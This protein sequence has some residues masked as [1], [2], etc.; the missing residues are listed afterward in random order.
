MA[1][2]WDI[3]RVVF[4]CFALYRLAGLISTEEGPYL[5]FLY[6]DDDQTG[7]FKWLREKAG[8]RPDRKAY[9]NTGRYVYITNLARGLS[10]PLCTA[11]YLAV[12][13]ILLMQFP[14]IPGNLILAW[15]GIWGV[16]TFLENLTSDEAVQS[17]IEEVA[18]SLEE[19]DGRFEN[20]GGT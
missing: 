9:D 18:E 19:N 14:S 8:A 17:A 16:Q 10:C 11:A 4:A 15:L 5:F 2:I 20:T 12:P 6:H 7:I 13:I 3:I 1:N